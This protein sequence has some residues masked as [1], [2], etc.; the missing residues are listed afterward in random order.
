MKNLGTIVLVLC[1]FLF[2][3]CTTAVAQRTVVKKT[4]NDGNVAGTMLRGSGKVAVI[5]V[6]SAAKATWATT[7]FGAKHVVAPL[8]LKAAPKLAFQ[9]L[10]T[11]GMAAKYL[12]PFA[13][14]LSLL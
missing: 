4:A 1:A 2:V 11:T 6:E 13:A 8:V 10:K 3:S 7:K 9:T 12:L 14:K 5:V